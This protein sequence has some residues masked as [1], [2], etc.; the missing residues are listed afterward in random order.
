[1]FYH[2]K[3]VRFL[4][5]KEPIINRTKP[6]PER[7]LLR[8]TFF[9]TELI[10]VDP[11]LAK[12]KA[13]QEKLEKPVEEGEFDDFAVLSSPSRVKPLS[14]DEKIQFKEVLKAH[15]PSSPLGGMSK[16]TSKESTSAESPVT[17][18][19]IQP[20]LGK[21]PTSSL[22]GT[23]KLSDNDDD[24]KPSTSTLQYAEIVFKESTS[25]GKLESMP[26]TSKTSDAEK[27]AKLDLINM[28]KTVSKSISL[29]NIGM[30]SKS[31]LSPTTTKVALETIDEK[32]IDK[33]TR[34][35]GNLEHKLE[36]IDDSKDLLTTPGAS[37]PSDEYPDP[38]K[39]IVTRWRIPSAVT[40]ALDL[41]REDD[42]DYAY[43]P[44]YCGEVLVRKGVD[45]LTIPLAKELR[46]KAKDTKWTT[47]YLLLRNK[48]LY[49]VSDKKTMYNCYMMSHTE[50]LE[51][52][53]DMRQIDR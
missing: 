25:A 26:S 8:G 13:M 45:Q 15:S 41:T 49:F 30:S 21:S 40:R 24:A 11:N 29:T 16:A 51:E 35:L 18:V 2:P 33:K 52:V 42:K 6:S 43:D 34:S 14:P 47:K 44:V 9:H 48:N 46:H 38:Y 32:N 1:M 50:F 36:L 23:S 27:Q 5:D 17:Y 53:S 31:L 3:E 20:V 22:A 10:G 19:E 4:M 37:S 28:S 12:A 7:I 39:G